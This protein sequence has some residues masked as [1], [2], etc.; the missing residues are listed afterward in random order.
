MRQAG[1][2]VTLERLMAGDPVTVI[3]SAQPTM[4]CGEPKMVGSDVAKQSDGNG[5]GRTGVQQ[6]E[7]PPRVRVRL[8]ADAQGLT[9]RQPEPI[10]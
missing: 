10:G 5:R 7:A 4:T 3:V 9:V 6:P 2:R 8:T 1:A